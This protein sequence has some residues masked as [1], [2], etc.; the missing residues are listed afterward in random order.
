MSLVF[1]N[2]L[3]IFVTFVVSHIPI[4]P[5]L[6]ESISE[7]INAAD[8][9]VFGNILGAS[10]AEIFPLNPENILVVESGSTVLLDNGIPP[11]CIISKLGMD[12]N[13]A[14][15]NNLIIQC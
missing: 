7:L 4:F 1:E 10:N 3:D 6:L 5:K 13:V 9:L 11:N 2:I 15:L 12:E 8:R 14:P